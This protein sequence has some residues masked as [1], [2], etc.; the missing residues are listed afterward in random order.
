MAV[1]IETFDLIVSDKCKLNESRKIILI[2]KMNCIKHSAINSSLHQL[3][4]SLTVQLFSFMKT[5]TSSCFIAEEIQH[6]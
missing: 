6:T 2:C 5:E 4:I 3:L 1:E